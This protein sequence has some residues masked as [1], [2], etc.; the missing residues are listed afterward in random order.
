MNAVERQGLVEKM[1]EFDATRDKHPMFKVM[2][3]YMRMVMQMLQFIRAVRTGD[4]KLHLQALQIFTKYFFAHDFYNYARMIPLY[5]AEM[6]SLATSDPEVYAEF[7]AGNWVVNK[8]S[9]VPF[10]ALGADHGLEHMNRSMK[11]NGG[12]VGITLNQTARTKFFLIA[13]EMA[14]LAEQARNMAGVKSKTLTRH[15]NQTLAV[16]S[17]ENKIVQA[18]IETIETFTNPFTEE[19]SDLFNVVTKVVMPDNIKKDLCNQSA[20]GQTLF[21][22]FVKERIQSEKVNIWSTMKKRKLLTWKSNAKKV[23]VSTKEN[24]IELREDR[25]LLPRMMMMKD[26]A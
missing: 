21:N 7:L 24:L 18:L 8:N 22:A 14:R 13:P 1:A 9:S 3:Q 19:S 26:F 20:I 6:D 15:H 10:C 23:K 12:L 11:V 16:L 5:L 25:S 17:R 2:R 4:W